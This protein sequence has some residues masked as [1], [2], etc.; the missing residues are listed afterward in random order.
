MWRHGSRSPCILI[1]GTKYKETYWKRPLEN[2]IYSG[3]I[4]MMKQVPRQTQM[5]TNY[6]RTIESANILLSS[7]VRG[8]SEFYPLSPEWLTN[9]TPIAIYTDF[10]GHPYIWK[11][12]ICKKFEGARRNREQSINS[13]KFR[14]KNRD[15]MEYILNV[16]K[17]ND[18]STISCIFDYFNIIKKENLEF[19]K[20]ITKSHFRKFKKFFNNYYLHSFGEALLGDFEDVDLIK[21]SGGIILKNIFEIFNNKINKGGISE[22]NFEAKFYGYSVHDYFIHPILLTLNIKQ[23]VLGDNY[24]DTG[25]MIIFELYQNLIYNDFDILILYSKNSTSPFEKVTKYVPECHFNDYLPFN[26]IS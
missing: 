7:F 16:A 12:S 20:Q 18:E 14:I 11:L 17:T 10:F 25:A 26:R 15:I 2:L 13:I 22:N 24:I 1:N 4:D 3:Q 21:Y 19:P 6:T 5:S 23:Q 9:Y 8:S